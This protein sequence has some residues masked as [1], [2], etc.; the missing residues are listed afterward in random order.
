MQ[1]KLGFM[2]L[3]QTNRWKQWFYTKDRIFGVE[4][5]FGS[6]KIQEP[7]LRRENGEKCLEGKNG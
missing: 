6:F 4:F 3:P 5:E 1:E 2:D 7:N